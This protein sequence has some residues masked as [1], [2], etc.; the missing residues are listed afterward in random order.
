MG[1]IMCA[2]LLGVPCLTFI[3][4]SYIPKDK[5]WLERNGWL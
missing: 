2:I 1:V 3:I 4:V 5:K